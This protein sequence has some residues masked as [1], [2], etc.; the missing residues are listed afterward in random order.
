MLLNPNL[1]KGYLISIHCQSRGFE[2]PFW[3]GLWILFR[4]GLLNPIQAMVIEYYASQGLWILH[5]V[6][7]LMVIESTVSQGL[8]NP[9][10]TK[11]FEYPASQGLLSLNPVRGY[12]IPS[13]QG[14]LNLHPVEGY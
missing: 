4:E 7:W 11:V 12:W 10:Q 9:I 3:E 6:I 2:S 5:P 1:V 8:L 13:S 14:L